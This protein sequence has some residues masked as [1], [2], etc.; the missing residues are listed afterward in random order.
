MEK[1]TRQDQA[2]PGPR[3]TGSAKH[4]SI[5][6]SDAGETQA[7]KG[8]TGITIQIRL[9]SGAPSKLVTRKN[10]EFWLNA[11]EE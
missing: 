1:K 3:S 2:A 10:T 9:K 5:S 6:R 8:Q 11:G 7:V 4:F